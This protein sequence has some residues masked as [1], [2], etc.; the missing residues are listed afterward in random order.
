VQELQRTAEWHFSRRGKITASR[1]GDVMGKESS[2]RYGNYLTEVA[3]GIVGI[4]GFDLEQP[5]FRDGKESEP[6]AKG[7]YEFRTGRTVV[8]VGF[9]PHPSI[10]YLGASPDGF[11][12]DGCIEIKSRT[13]FAAHLESI[14][15]VPAVY[16]PQVQ[17]EMWVTGRP[18]NDFVSFWHEGDAMALSVVRV[19]PDEVL[20]TKM[21]A[22][23]ALFWERAQELADQLRS[24][25]RA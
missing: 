6:R 25:R 24:K 5:W 21:E 11:V 17:G 8:E 23:C 13:S 12:E 7:L 3:Y 2:K 9:I 1:L 4:S 14:D 20:I 18:W 16:R 10:P 15:R 22:A 19:V